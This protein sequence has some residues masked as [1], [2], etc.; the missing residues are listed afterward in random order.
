MIGNRNCPAERFIGVAPTLPQSSLK[1]LV[2][3]LDR[4]SDSSALAAALLK[5][6]AL[7]ESQQRVLREVLNDATLGEAALADAG[8]S[9]TFHARE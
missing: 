4:I 2:E 5:N 6:P 9:A 3:D 7:T 1:E 8:R